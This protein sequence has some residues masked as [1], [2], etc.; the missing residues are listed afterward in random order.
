MCWGVYIVLCLCNHAEKEGSQTWGGHKGSAD[1]EN[2]DFL[3]VLDI[4]ILL[5]GDL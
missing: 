5:L 3:H 1:G 2:G 4:V